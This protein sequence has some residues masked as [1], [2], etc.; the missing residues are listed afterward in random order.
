MKK[1]LTALLSFGLSLVTCDALAQ[2]EHLSPAPE[3]DLA[4]ILKELKD[5]VRAANSGKSSWREEYFG[6]LLILA[7]NLDRDGRFDDAKAV[8]S[9]AL[10]T[11]EPLISNGLENSR[12]ANLL[13]H[14]SMLQERYMDDRE[15]AHASAR[16]ATEADP[17]NVT[18]QEASER[19]S[20][21]LKAEEMRQR[22]S[23]GE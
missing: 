1:I 22:L 6:Y 16:A 21:S 10:T 14:Q 5:E 4:V 8:A 7:T 19:L 12:R 23:E 11:I 17:K 15:S 3:A 13:I 2:V 20:E 18:A 9:E